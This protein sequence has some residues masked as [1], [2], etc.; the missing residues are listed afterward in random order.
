MI[1]LFQQYI[2]IRK[3]IFIIG[4]GLLV[5]LAITLT[6]FLILGRSVGF[7]D[8]LLLIWPRVLLVTVITQISLYFND[9]YEF[10]N[11]DSNL[12]IAA[13]LV[14]AVGITSMAL[15]FVY[16]LWPTMVVGRWIFFISLIALL[17]F[18]VSW[19][20]LYNVVIKKKLFTEKAVIIG[21]GEL[22]KDI[23]HEV[24]EKRDNNFNIEFLITNINGD[25]EDERLKDIPIYYGFDHVVDLVK[26]EN[27]KNIIVAFDEKRGIFPYR[28]LLECKVKGINIIDGVTFYERITGKLMVEKIN[29]S[30]FIFSDGFKKSRTSRI[31]K[32]VKGLVLSTIMLVLLSPIMLLV[33]IIIK[34]DSKGPMLFSQERV[35]ENEEP[36]ILHK[37]RSMRIDAEAATGPVWAQKDDPRVTKVGRIIRKLRIDELPQLWNVFKGEM[38]FVGPRPERKFFVDYLKEKIPYYNERFTVKPGVTGWAQIRYPYGAS[39]KDALEKLKYDLYYIKNMSIA[40]DFLVIFQTV[41]TVLLRRGGR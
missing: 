39:E 31:I 18:I 32:R 29:P 6:A 15:A 41:K 17:F 34:L 16:L 11:T 22:V 27:V 23:L 24:K 30:W 36:F 14:Q 12:D 37:F 1:H 13:R 9:L 2:P 19:R 33:A 21:S 7:L 8:T 28:Q 3:L 40:F 26:D 10:K 25:S 4:E 20:F 38:S 5:F 35:G